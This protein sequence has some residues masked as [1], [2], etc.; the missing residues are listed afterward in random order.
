MKV[1]LPNLRPLGGLF[2]AQVAAGDEMSA[3][4]VAGTTAWPPYKPACFIYLGQQKMLPGMP[5]Q[6]ENTLGEAN[7]IGHFEQQIDETKQLLMLSVN[8]SVTYFESISPWNR[9]TK[10]GLKF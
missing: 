10:L 8:F 4:D 7:R 6:A 5:E 3:E 2:L 1:D 9:H